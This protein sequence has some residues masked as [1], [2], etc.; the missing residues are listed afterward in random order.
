M[1]AHADLGTIV[2]DCANPATLAAFYQAATGWDVTYSDDDYVYLGN[3]GPIQLA[4]QRPTVIRRQLLRGMQSA[5]LDVGE[6]GQGIAIELV[7]PA[8]G[9][10][11]RQVLCVAQIFHDD[12]AAPRIGGVHMGHVRAGLLQQCRYL[13]IRRDVF[14]AGGRIHDDER[15][16]LRRPSGWVDV[17]ARHAEIATEAGVSRCHCDSTDTPPQVACQPG[18]N[19]C[20]A[21]V[22]LEHSYKYSAQL[23]QRP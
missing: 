5:Y 21:R 15:V 18:P 23:C 11:Q 12:E 8:T 22:V 16:G 13:E 14:L 2:F 1:P 4:F 20:E 10:Q 6:R 7:N 17:T 9:F 3:S 19:E